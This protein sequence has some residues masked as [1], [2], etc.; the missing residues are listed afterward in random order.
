MADFSDQ[1]FGYQ[2]VLFNN[3]D[4]RLD[5]SRNNYVTLWPGD[6]KPGLWMN[7]I[8][9]MG[10]IYTLLMRE[11]EIF[12]EERKRIGHYGLSL[13]RD[14]DIEL[15]IPP[16]S[17][18]ARDLYWGAICDECKVVPEMERAEEMLMMKAKARSWPQISWAIINLGLVK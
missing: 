2:D 1:Y 12:I 3:S 7:S 18:F 9:R 5:L 13:D 6:G 4:G 10:A 16:G 17:R 8:V 14:E 15:V 11:E